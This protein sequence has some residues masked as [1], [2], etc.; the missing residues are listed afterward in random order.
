VAF[1][2]IAG[3]QAERGLAQHRVLALPP[4]GVERAL[5]MSGLA[6]A[7]LFQSET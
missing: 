6:H 2:L 7:R 3:G 1:D 4:A 5:C